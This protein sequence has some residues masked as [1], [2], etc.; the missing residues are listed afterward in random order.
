MRSPVNRRLRC[1]LLTQDFPISPNNAPTG[2][3]SLI[4]SHLELLAHAGVD[5]TLVVIVDRH[6]SWGFCDH[7]R[8]EPETWEHVKSLCS[9][10]RI[11]PLERLVRTPARIQYF[12]LAL[13]DPLSYLFTIVNDQTIATL[14]ELVAEVK[15]DFLWGEHRLPSLFAWRAVPERPLVHSHQDWAWRL[16]WKEFRGAT[17]RARLLFNCWALW[18]VETSLVRHAAGNVSASVSDA[19]EFVRLGSRHTAY[20]P[21]TYPEPP[22][23][24]VDGLTGPVRLVHLGAMK[25]TASRIGLARFLDTALADLWKQMSEPPELW[26]IGSLEGAEEPLRHK[27]KDPRV[28]C[29]GFVRDLSSVLRP[30]DIHVVPWEYNTGSR[31]RIPIALSRAQVIVATKAS[32]ACLPELRDGENC[33][34]VDD[35]A[36]MARLLPTLVCDETRRHR[37]GDAARTTFHQ[38]F[39]RKA[40]QPRFDEFISELVG[41]TLP[42][43]RSEPGQEKTLHVTDQARV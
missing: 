9:G 8:R 17:S 31:T 35:L 3:S 40:I 34:L 38:H 21:T 6:D 27:L 13:R 22:T 4:Y 11:L 14:R 24:D 42:D 15:P 10:Y 18:R 19:A 7:V 23:A 32:A 16:N 25:T 33:C 36:A 28:V 39:T 2:A 5:V 1:L 37:L 12:L 43:A 29:T 20:L 30:Y 41:S 26:V